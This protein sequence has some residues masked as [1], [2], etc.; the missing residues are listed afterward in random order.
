MTR[1]LIWIGVATAVLAAVLVGLAAVRAPQMSPFDEWTHADYAWRLAHGQVPE[2][3]TPVAPEVLQELACRGVAGYV[4]RL[5]PCGQIDPDPAAFPSR[6]EDYNFSHP[7]LY[8]GVTGGLARLADAVV[9]GPHFF[10]LA[11]LVGVLWLWAAMLVLFLALR[12]FDVPQKYA[13]L[14][15]VLLPL[16]PG[17]LR[18]CSTVNN[19]AA[20]PLA[21]ALALLVFARFVGQH[22]LGW[23]FPTVSALLIVA[24]KVINVLPLLIVAVALG[25]LA[26]S[27]WRSEDRTMARHMVL[28]VAGIGAAFLVVYEGWALFQAGRGD[29]NW[30][31]PVAGVSDRPMIGSPFGELVSTLLKGMSPES[32]YFLP[33]S[34]NGGLLVLWGRALDVAI[35]AA[36]LMA[37]TAW[38]RRST[39]WLIGAIT[40]AGLVAYPLVVEFQVYMSTGHYFPSVNPRYGLS[41]EPLALACVIMVAW[42]RGALRLLAMGTLAGGLAV[43]ATVGGLVA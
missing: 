38:A 27:K 23:V 9:P 22:R 24:T 18:A 33:M 11:R 2:A 10:V 19:D 41:M 29:P 12:A 34:I 32:D 13:V 25:V 15:T 31:N 7:P 14:G 4:P 6:G 20:A 37:L 1:P 36:P 5:A 30:V 21:G 28:A 26:V 3:G 17:V 40:L 42:K 43:L 39:A 8:Y 35:V 16:F